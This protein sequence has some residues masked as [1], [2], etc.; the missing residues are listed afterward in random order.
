[1]NDIQGGRSTTEWQPGPRTLSDSDKRP[2]PG[3][4]R[5]QRTALSAQLVPTSAP[6]HP[7]GST[8]RENAPMASLEHLLS[9]LDPRSE[10][11]GLQFER[12]CRW[13]LSNDPVYRRE[14]R[15]VWLWKDWPHRWGPDAGID[16]VAEAQNG[17][18]GPK[19][20]SALCSEV[21]HSA[22]APIA[23]TFASG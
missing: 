9:R 5:V 7:H 3:L 20:S 21:T 23:T 11:R 18:P 22:C 12:T 13:Y 17:V 8:A 2:G 1:M 15:R 14:L 19:A 10:V 4:A 16:L 6:L